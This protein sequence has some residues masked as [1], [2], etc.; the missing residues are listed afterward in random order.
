M[1][2]QVPGAGSPPPS[3]NQPPPPP[4]SSPA[5][6]VLENATPEALKRLYDKSPDLFKG[7]AVP[8]A[9]P[10]PPVAPP[11]APVAGEEL[12]LELPQGANVNPKVLD[13][14]KERWTKAAPEK[15]AQ[16]VVD[17]YLELNKEAYDANRAAFEG[18]R[19]KN[20]ES[21]KADPEW[22]DFEAAKAIAQKPLVKYGTPE[23]AKA[24]TESGW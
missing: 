24:L 13:R 8:A 4:A 11:P 2:E 18:W 21:L 16:A 22:R 9:P 12:K 14:F 19:K 17:F 7:I 5:L 23:L 6:A 1:A 15:R 20:E 3:Q 10:A